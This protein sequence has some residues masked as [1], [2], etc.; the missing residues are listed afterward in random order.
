MAGKVMKLREVDAIEIKPSGKIVMQPVSG[1]PVM[2]LGLKQ[3]LKVGDQFPM[4]LTFEKAGKLNVVVDVKEMR[5]GM[6]M[7][8]SPAHH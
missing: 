1:Y 3:P 5:P 7:S 2:L 4:T 6:Q 8:E